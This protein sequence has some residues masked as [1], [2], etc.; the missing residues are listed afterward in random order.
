MKK[1]ENLRSKRIATAMAV[2]VGAVGLSACNGNRSQGD[3]NLRAS[4]VLEVPGESGGEVSTFECDSTSLKVKLEMNN[5]VDEEFEISN[6]DICADG[7]ITPADFTLG[8]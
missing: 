8:K 5:S 2:A 3:I 7:K 1:F 4:G 6:S